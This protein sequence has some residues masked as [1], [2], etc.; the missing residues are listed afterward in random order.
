[1]QM[2][3]F[4]W[5]Y[6]GLAA[7]PLPPPRVLLACD[8]MPTDGEFGYGW[9]SSRIL[10]SVAIV[11]QENGENNYLNKKKRRLHK[12][13]KLYAA[14]VFSIHNSVMFGKFQ[15]REVDHLS[16]QNSTHLRSR[17]ISPPPPPLPLQKQYLYSKIHEDRDYRKEKHF[18]F[19]FF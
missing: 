2:S 5:C 12:S 7:I 14:R 3:L 16:V 15:S 13:M 18:G 9:R 8:G 11:L 1:M 6:R 4:S 17:L 19:P 10:T